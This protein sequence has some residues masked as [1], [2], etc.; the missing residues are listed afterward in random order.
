MTQDQSLGD[1]TPDAPTALQKPPAIDIDMLT[2]PQ[3]TVSDILTAARLPERRA[4]VC[5]RADLQA[6]YDDILTELGTLV[7]ARGELVVD[8]EA[9]MGEQTAISRAQT[10][11]PELEAVRA[12]MA[13][14]MW[15]PLFRGMPADDLAVLEKEHPDAAELNLRLIA[16]CAVDPKMTYDDVK[17][18]RRKLPLKAFVG[19]IDAARSVCYSAGVDVPKSL[20]FLPARKEQ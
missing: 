20:N 4:S 6:R 9:A 13:G 1:T 2:G 16:A 18:L 10:L 3:L 14:S 7:D 15:R 17:Q 5:L 19:L 12:E 11:A 8:P